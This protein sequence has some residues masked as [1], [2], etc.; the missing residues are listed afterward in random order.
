MLVKKLWR[1]VWLVSILMFNANT[2]RRSSFSRNQRREAFLLD[3]RIDET[4]NGSST[5]IWLYSSR[6][7]TDGSFIFGRMKSFSSLI[8]H[9]PLA[10]RC[11]ICERVMA[12]PTFLGAL[13]TNETTEI[14]NAP[15]LVNTSYFFH[16]KLQVPSQTLSF[17]HIRCTVYHQLY[18]QSTPSS[19]LSISIGFST[20]IH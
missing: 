4:I 15:S 1:M 12:L 3:F 9:S 13:E 6:S 8:L 5:L 17:T 10:R 2:A 16:L 11:L 19:S 18:P 14:R 20:S 7:K